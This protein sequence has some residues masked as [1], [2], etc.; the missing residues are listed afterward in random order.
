MCMKI[1]IMTVSKVKNYGSALL[2]YATQEIFK[3]VG[4]DEIEFINYKRGRLEE[5]DNI[6]EF[7]KGICDDAKH[8]LNMNKFVKVIF[9]VVKLPS[10]LKRSKVFN[11]FLNKNL[12][13]TISYKEQKELYNNPPRAD[14]YCTGGDQMW[15]EMYNGHK[16]LLPFYLD[17]VDANKP[18]VSFGTSFGKSELDTWEIEEITQLLKRYNYI[19]V[20]EESG[21]KIIERMNIENARNILDPTLALTASQW[22]KFA[23]KKQGVNNYIL[24]YR[25]SRES[26]VLSVARKIAR[27]T[28]KK[29]IMLSYNWEDKLR[30][31]H[32]IFVPTP[33]EF[34]GLIKNAE[35]VVSDS[36]HATAFAIN[37]NVKFI[38][39]LPSKTAGRIENIVNKCGLSGRIWKENVNIYN[40][41]ENIDFSEANEILQREREKIYDSAMVIMNI[42]Q[43]YK[44][45]K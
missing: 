25:V 15:N 31:V 5:A 23:H 45:D 40:Y 37:L 19:T 8:N 4:F 35:Y 42:A 34:V 32:N 27:V 17:F 7:Y 14:I 29:I 41:V 12:N 1:S 16:T 21:C 11:A 44:E 28:R 2:C 22:I 39:V 6:S 26:D 10:I 38:T 20:R 33:E 9:F 36:F 24:V 30:F 43:N 18:K 13:Y 3:Q